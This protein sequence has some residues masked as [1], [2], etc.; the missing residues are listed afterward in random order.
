MLVWTIWRSVGL[1][2]LSG[3]AGVGAGWPRP[4]V[5]CGPCTGA[6]GGATGGRATTAVAQV[7][8]QWSVLLPLCARA[9][10]LPASTYSARAATATLMDFMAS[11]LFLRS[12][13]Y[14]SSAT[15]VKEMLSSFL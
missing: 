3:G 6:A 9:G 15:I 2:K 8:T 1:L 7:P 5:A 14:R 12:R 13:F 10:G 4:C 11:L